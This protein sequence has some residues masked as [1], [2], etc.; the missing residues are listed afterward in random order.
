[1]P[2]RIIAAKYLQWET[3]SVVCSTYLDFR[4]KKGEVLSKKLLE[5]KEITHS[6]HHSRT[7]IVLP[8]RK[9]ESFFSSSRSKQSWP[10]AEWEGTEAGR[11]RE[12]GQEAPITRVIRTHI[13][14]FVDS[15]L[16]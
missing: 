1:M 15:L 6:F 8:T 5:A 3:G 11:G 16:N 2:C 12:K 13:L 10:S 4:E 7:K 14:Q 9:K